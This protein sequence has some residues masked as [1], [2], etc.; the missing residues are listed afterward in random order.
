MLEVMLELPWPPSTNTYWR[1]SGHHIHI[2]NKG[3]EY[4]K[5]VM[6]EIALLDVQKFGDARVSVSMQL[7]PPN[8]RKYDIDNRCKALFDALSH[9]GVWNDD[10]Q[11]DILKIYKLNPAQGGWVQ[12]TIKELENGTT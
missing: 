4:R 6:D 10:E 12:I 11:V 9:A 8:L 2:S 1:R 7:I 5:A 3:R